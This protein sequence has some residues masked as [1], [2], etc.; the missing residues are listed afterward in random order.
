MRTNYTKAKL[1]QQLMDTRND[2]LYDIF[3]NLQK[4]FD[5]SDRDSSLEIIEG[6]VVVPCSLRLLKQYCDCLTMMERSGVYYGF[7]F[8]R[9]LGVT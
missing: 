8:K 1:I 5:A 2:V 7:P 4:E 6:G 3:L 9:Y